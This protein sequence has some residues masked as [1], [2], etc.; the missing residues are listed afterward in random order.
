MSHL[1]GVMVPRLH[2]CG[3]LDNASFAVVTQR[4]EGT[5]LDDAC[6]PSLLGKAEEVGLHA[7]VLLRSRLYYTW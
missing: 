7:A 5:S 4:I 6:S 2:F 3:Y 1:Q